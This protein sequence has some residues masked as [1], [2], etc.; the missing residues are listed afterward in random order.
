MIGGIL[1]AFSVSAAGLVL[2]AYLDA[3]MAIDEMNWARVEAG[4]LDWDEPEMWA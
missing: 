1:L 2:L 4:E 3:S